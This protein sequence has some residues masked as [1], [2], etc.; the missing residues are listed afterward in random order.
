MGG[1]CVPAVN[2]WVHT[3]EPARSDGRRVCTCS[4]PVGAHPGTS[5][6]VAE[7]ILSAIEK[8]GLAKGVFSLV[9]GGNRAVGQ[10]LVQHPLIKAVG[11]TGSLGGGRALF[12]LCAQ[13][14]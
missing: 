10:A 9:Q 2:L 3:L 1:R 13:R 14:S 6:I 4:E 11:F 8:C 5:E 12:D 7:A